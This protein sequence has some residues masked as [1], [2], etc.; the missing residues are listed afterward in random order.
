MF[1]E[2]FNMTQEMIVSGVFK[3]L[4]NAK[5][6]KTH[7]SKSKMNIECMKILFVQDLSIWISHY[8][9]RNSFPP[10]DQPISSLS[11]YGDIIGTN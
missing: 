2:Y 5:K 6:T 9:Q 3:L 11:I 8:A 7:C 4:G 10:M 1:S